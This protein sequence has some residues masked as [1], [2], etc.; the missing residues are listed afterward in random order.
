[1]MRKTAVGE[2]PSLGLIPRGLPSPA[3]LGRLLSSP[4]MLLT[5]R[6]QHFPALF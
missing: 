5:C 4:V 6:R 2:I 1:M 3:C